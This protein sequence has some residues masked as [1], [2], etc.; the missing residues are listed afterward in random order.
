MFTPNESKFELED[1]MAESFEVLVSEMRTRSRN[2]LD[3]EE[4]EFNSQEFLKSM[5]VMLE[6]DKKNQ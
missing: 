3:K 2:V 4:E 6:K 5:N 1:Q